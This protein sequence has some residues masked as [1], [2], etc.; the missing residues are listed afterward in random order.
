MSSR[1][2]YTKYTFYTNYKISL[3]FYFYKITRV[4][5]S[6]FIKLDIK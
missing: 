6:A 1:Y 2:Y 3:I 4:T 5:L